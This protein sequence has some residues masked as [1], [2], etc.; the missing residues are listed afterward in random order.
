MYHT[1]NGAL[2]IDMCEMTAEKGNKTGKLRL[3]WISY[4]ALCA[5]RKKTE[6]WS[7]DSQRVQLSSA[8]QDKVLSSGG[9]GSTGGTLKTS[10]WDQC[11]IKTH[12]QSQVI[13]ETAAGFNYDLTHIITE[14][15]CST[16]FPLLAKKSMTT[17]ETLS[18]LLTEILTEL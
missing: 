12:I 9:D 11:L 3:N 13:K 1:F 5:W 16:A 6:R 10:P 15:F 7:H 4:L 14:E 18:I 8:V 17:W 2:F